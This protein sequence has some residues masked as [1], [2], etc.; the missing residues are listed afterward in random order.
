ME[1]FKLNNLKNYNSSIKVIDNKIRFNKNFDKSLNS[2]RSNNT[3]N[4]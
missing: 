2:L 3:G 1:D 4:N